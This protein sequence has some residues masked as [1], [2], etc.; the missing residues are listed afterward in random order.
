MAIL[1]NCKHPS[2]PLFRQH[3]GFL[4]P[5]ESAVQLDFSGI[6]F[7]VLHRLHDG[8]QEHPK[9]ILGNVIVILKSTD[10]SLAALAWD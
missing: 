5:A 1:H 4:E 7:S 9:Q 3:C 10:L 2:A 6:F 8:K